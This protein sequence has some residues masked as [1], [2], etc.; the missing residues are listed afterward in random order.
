ML[1]RALCTSS[2]F[3]GGLPH[4]QLLR[5]MKLTAIILLSACLTASAKGYSQITLSEKNVPLQNV[6]KEIKRQTGYDVFY[7]YETIQKAGKVT[8]NVKDVSLQEALEACLKT[9]ALTYVIIDRTVVIKEKG[10]APVI[11]ENNQL[12]IPPPIDVKGRIVN[13]NGEPVLATVMVKGTNKGTTT[14]NDGYFELDGVNDNATLVITASNIETREIKLNGKGDLAVIDVKMKNSPLDEMQIIAYGRTSKRFQTGNVTSVKADDIEKQPVNN[15][16]LALEGRVPGLFIEQA[17]GLPGSGV[18]VRIQGQNSI[19]NGND[20]LYVVDGVP[21]ISLLLPSINSTLGSSGTVGIV[22]NPFSYL[23][24][25]D[26]ESIEVLKDADATAIYGSRAANGAILI[27]TKK[28]RAGKT[29]VSANLQNGWGQVTRKMDLL[30]SQQYLEMRHE[31]LRNDGISAPGAFDYDLNGFWDTTRYTDWQ[32]ELIGKIARYNDFQTSV[33][34]GS[35]NTQFVI[36]AGYHRETSTFPG[37]YADQKGS[38]HFNINNRSNNQKFHIQLTGNYL[39]DDNRLPSIDLTGTALG[40]PPVAPPLFNEDGSLNF[41]VN[42]S[43]S[44]SF[45][46]PLRYMTTE[47]QNKTHNLTSNLDIGYQI[48][49]DIQIKSRFG[50][51][52]MQMNEIETSPITYFLPEQRITG[53]R[54][55]TFGNNNISSFIIEPQLIFNKA[56]RKGKLDA[57]V[58]TTLQQMNSVG[59]LMTAYGYNSD[60][61]LKDIKAAPNI[62]VFSSTYS[63]YKYNAL[64]GRINYNLKEKYIINL[65]A[66]RDGSSRFGRENQF[67]NFGAIG[68]AWIFSEESFVKKRLQFLSFGKLRASYGTTGNDQ[69]GDYTFLNQYDPITLFGGIPYQGIPAIQPSRIA[70]PYLQWEETRK[71]QAG[72]DLG[73]FKDRILLNTTYF[74]NRSSNQLLYYNLPYITGFPNLLLNFP[75]TVQNAGWEF[76]L[77]SE[78]I[79][80][81]AFNWKTSINLTIPKSKLIAFQNL[82]SS[83]YKTTLQIGMPINIKQV[84]ALAGVDPQTGIYQ[85]L[86]ADGKL[87]ANPDFSK[88]RTRIIRLD[89]SYYGGFQNSFTYKGFQLDILLQFVKQIGPNFNFGSI[90]P[91]YFSAGTGNQPAWTLNRWQKPGDAA[92][93][94]KFG[95]NFN[96]FTPWL[97]ALG[98]D[99]AYSDA[100]YI[101]LKNLSLSFLLP[102]QWIRKIQ[103]QSFRIFVQGQNLLTFTHYKG[104]DPETKSSASLPPLR[105]LTFG[106]DLN[107]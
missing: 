99:A 29:K 84:F 91:G 67:H 21:Y 88:D 98:T 28:G 76:T 8:V 96:L 68:G 46:N 93:Y 74:R 43:G 58:G 26:I 48:T 65:T 5:I 7:T 97:N 77:N 44:S 33:S 66:R 15:P 107:L 80:G 83:S 4:K 30:N 92:T 11:A 42:A 35:S 41:S 24:P 94:E 9:T 54:S 17:T 2:C 104:L 69:I 27:T 101:R 64:F 45:S 47:Y 103:S 87:T 23:N 59:Q 51:S 71:F 72:L 13:E 34:G 89:P 14:N 90:Y 63:I 18:K 56:F 49:R 61:V 86:D 50:Y 62:S 16:L 25:A 75:A 6:F 38:L 1:L 85:F 20:P 79:R 53:I 31:A 100:S 12:P 81:K 36:G 95:S 52:N 57:L 40:L 70:N 105:V 55:A 78:N 19:Q 106:L 32:K 73:L 102:K 22:G 10:K 37:D 60:L 39:Y 3:T 82:E